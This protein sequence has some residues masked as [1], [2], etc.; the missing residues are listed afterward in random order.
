MDEFDEIDGSEDVIDSRDIIARIAHLASRV[1]DPEEIEVWG[2]LNESEKGELAALRE[3]A[4]EA[5]ACSE[6]WW[7]GVTLINDD[8]FEDYARELARDIGA[9]SD[10]AGWPATCIDWK[11]AADELKVDYTSVEYDGYT[12]WLR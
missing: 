3:L 5:S 12:F 11:K 6:D 9:I 2:E 8:Y 10:D 4:K 7:H 1:D